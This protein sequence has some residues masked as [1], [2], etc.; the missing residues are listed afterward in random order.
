MHG[1]APWP[2][3]PARS[4]ARAF[5]SLKSRFFRS[6]R[7]HSCSSEV[8][9]ATVFSPARAGITSHPS[10]P[11]LDG[12]L[13]DRAASRP[14]RSSSRTGASAA[15]LRRAA[16]GASGAAAAASAA[17]A[18]AVSA[19]AEVSPTAAASASL[20]AGSGTTSTVGGGD[21][22]AA[23]GGERLGDALEETAVRRASRSAAFCSSEAARMW[24]RASGPTPQQRRGSSSC[25]HRDEHPPS[26][27]PIMSLMCHTLVATAGL[28]GSLVDTEVQS[29]ERRRA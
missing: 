25:S 22:P 16:S 4:A 19:A 27:T 7:S 29:I 9:C 10:T 23:A 8:V 13:A 24:S 18:A 12:R 6:R 20:G 11:S 2:L 28:R 17:A 21:G 26:W 14:N 15:V 1:P 5:A 3:G